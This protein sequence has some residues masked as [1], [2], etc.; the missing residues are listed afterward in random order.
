MRG[1]GISG[2]ALAMVAMAV[3]AMTMTPLASAALTSVVT[4]PVG[5][6]LFHAPAFQDIVR[7]EI[8]ESGGTFT[9]SMDVA[10]PIPVSP[11][12][13]P[14]GENQIWWDFALL[15]SLAAFPQGFPFARGCN[16]PFDF[17]IHVVWDGTSFSG[18]LID[19]RPLLAGEPAVVASVPFSFAM[20]RA[21][22]RL[23][24]DAAMIGGPSTF[25]WASATLDWSGPLG[26]CSLS[27][28]DFAPNT[29]LATWPS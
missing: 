15:T 18:M 29:S 2:S 12:L 20:D 1:G 3:A 7:S 6:V 24:V 16:A 28:V 19:R 10:G 8:R 27:G 26:T 21:E 25:L 5:D 9:L 17:F 13:P 4:D 14:P 23:F 11:A 22:V